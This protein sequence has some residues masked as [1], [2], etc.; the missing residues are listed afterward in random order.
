MKGMQNEE[1]RSE[2]NE[3]RNWKNMKLGENLEKWK[4]LQDDQN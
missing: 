4:K 2:E 1:M 3:E